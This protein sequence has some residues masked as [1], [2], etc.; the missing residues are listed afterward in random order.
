MIK[1]LLP[2]L[3]WWGLRTGGSISPIRCRADSS[4]ELALQEPLPQIV[5]ADEPTGNLDT[6]TTIDVMKLMVRICHENGLTLVLVSHDR[7]I[8]AF[9]DRIITIVDGK[10]VSDTKDTSDILKNGD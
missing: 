9:A 8:A 1:S 2:C 4:S 5:F 6:K 10:I 3:I 7:E